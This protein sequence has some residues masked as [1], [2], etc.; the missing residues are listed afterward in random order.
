[1]KIDNFESDYLSDHNKKNLLIL[2]TIR[3]SKSI[4]RT[5][6]SKITQLNIVT[7]SNYVA[8]FIDRGLVVEKGLDVSSGGR[9]PTIIQ[10]NN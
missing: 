3:R 5:D 7:V 9:R 1:M 6:I 8:D 2:E 4:S 10:L